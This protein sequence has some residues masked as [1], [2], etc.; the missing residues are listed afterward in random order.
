MFEILN[1]AP[2]DVAQ[3]AV[4]QVKWRM[5]HRAPH[6]DFNDGLAPGAPDSPENRALRAVLREIREAE[7]SR[8]SELSDE[9]TRRY[10]RLLSDLLDARRPPLSPAMVKRADATLEEMR[11]KYGRQVA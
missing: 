4:Y 7:G 3:E 9:A 10:S 5:Y 8:I 1:E 2:Y 11:R 6:Q